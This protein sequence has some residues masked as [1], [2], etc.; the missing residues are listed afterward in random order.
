MISIQELE[1]GD[2]IIH[3]GKLC[4]IKNISLEQDKYNI[5]LCGVFS[6]QEHSLAIEPDASLDD[7]GI[8]R[9]CGHVISKKTKSIEI[10]DSVSYETFEA[11]IDEALFNEVSGEDKVTYIRFNKNAKILEVRK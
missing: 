5:E 1:K 6:K 2:F 10:M 11:E 8:M 3:E 4:Q 7:S 9:R